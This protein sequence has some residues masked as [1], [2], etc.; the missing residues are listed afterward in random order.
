MTK[1]FV[2]N[3]GVLDSRFLSRSVGLLDPRP[4]LVLPETAFVSEAIDLFQRNKTGSV[5][6]VNEEEKLTGMFTERDVVLKVFRAD[7][8]VHS[9]RL[10][11][12][13]T[14]DPKSVKMTTTLAFALNLMSAGGYRHLPVCDDES[15]PIAVLSVKDIVD[16]VAH[17]LIADLKAFP[18][19]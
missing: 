9:T 11:E 2:A 7:V 19:E 10:V 4:A 8:S 5:V 13:M 17:S 15:R 12:V 14:R 3:P 6:I 18:E 16:Y 1:R